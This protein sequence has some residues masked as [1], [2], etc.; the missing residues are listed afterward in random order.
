MGS[1]S[2]PGGAGVR[3]AV[4]DYV[5][6]GSNDRVIEVGFRSK[7]Y[8]IF[9]RIDGVRTYEDLLAFDSASWTFFIDGGYPLKENESVVTSSGVNVG[10]I[11]FLQGGGNDSGVNFRIIAFA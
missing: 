5:G 2:A 1:Y 11:W 6:D 9:R 10:R 3:Q 7:F 8:A 4:V